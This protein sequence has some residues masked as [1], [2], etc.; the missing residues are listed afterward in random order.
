MTPACAA[1]M[2]GVPRVLVLKWWIVAWDAFKLDDR[3]FV[4]LLTAWVVVLALA[5]YL[6]LGWES[7]GVL[8]TVAGLFAIATIAAQSR[9]HRRQ[10]RRG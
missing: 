4:A 2:A 7:A 6:L 5:T 8:I 1:T 3:L 10:D 9:P